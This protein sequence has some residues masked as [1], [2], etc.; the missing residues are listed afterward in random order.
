MVMFIS[1]KRKVIYGYYRG[2]MWIQQCSPCS[3]STQLKI[4]WMLI[5]FLSARPRYIFNFL[6][7]NNKVHKSFCS[8]LFNSQEGRPH[9]YSKPNN[10]VTNIG[11]CNLKYQA[12]LH[13]VYWAKKWRNRFIIAIKSIIEWEKELMPHSDFRLKYIQMVFFPYKSY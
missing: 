6:V 3:W 8:N 1:N 2:F 9:G 4:K 12:T 11:L 7:T 10:Q 5:C 13:L